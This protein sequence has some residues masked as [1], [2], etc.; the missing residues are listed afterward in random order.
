MRYRTIGDIE[1]Q[2]ICGSGLVDLLAQLRLSGKMSLLGLFEDGSNEFFFAPERG[3]SLSR[4]DV[5]SLAQA[6]AANYCGQYIVLRRYGVDPDQ[7]DAVYLAGAFANYVNVDS[8]VEIGFIA[9]VTRDKVSKVGN[10]ALEGATLMLTSKDM[11]QAAEDMAGKIEHVELET[12]P[13]FFDIFVEGCMFKPMDRRL[14]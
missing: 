5:S 3:M 14:V 2:G 10:A 6:K 4:S 12:T 13:D 8:A 1:P 11:R 9:N 7:L